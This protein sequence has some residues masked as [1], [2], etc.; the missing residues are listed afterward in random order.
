LGSVIKNELLTQDGPNTEIKE[1]ITALRASVLILRLVGRKLEI[2][3][4][5]IGVLVLQMKN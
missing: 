5:F 2:F 1:P 3:Q 4:D